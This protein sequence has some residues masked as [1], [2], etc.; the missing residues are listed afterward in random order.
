MSPQLIGETHNGADDNASGTAGLIELAYALARD[1]A[2]R[3]RGYL[4]IAFAGEEI[5]LNGSSYWANNPTYPLDKTVAMLNLD[6]I[7]RPRNN[8]V[9]LGGIGTSPTFAEITKA[10]ATEAGIEAKPSSQG[11]YGASDH[12][13]FYMKNLPVLFFFSG[14]HG[15]Y[16]RPSDDWQL[17]DGPGAVKIVGMVYGVATRLNVLD[18]RPQFTKVDEPAGG[19][20]RGAGGSGYGASFGSVPD[21]AADVQ[22]V[23]FADV[24]PNSP[25]AKAGLK[26]GDTLVRFAGKEV[27]SLEDFSYI[28][29]MHK[30]GDVVE[31]VVIRDGQPMTVQVKLDVRR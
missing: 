22:G 16:H 6:M 28:L 23:R 7:G 30:P 14:L 15:D 10:A 19:A 17:I 1:P 18:A 24:R 26:G 12:A 11:G 21:M 31:V 20:R 9:M 8:A 29:R 4:F 27:K 2:P 5:G 13:S 25:A 3:K